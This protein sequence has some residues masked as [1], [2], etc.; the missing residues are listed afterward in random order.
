[1]KTF[2]EVEHKMG[3]IPTPGSQFRP[4][5]P[6][7]NPNIRKD[8]VT[9]KRKRA[10][11]KKKFRPATPKPTTACPPLPEAPQRPKCNAPLPSVPVRESTPWPG[12]GKV[13]GNLF[14]GRNWLLPQNHLATENKNENATGITSPRPPIKEELKT[15]EHSL[16]K[17]GWVPDCPFCKSQEKRK[18]EDKTQKQ[19]KAS[20]QAK[21]QKPQAR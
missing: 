1:M 4:P 13:S 12:A 8:T 2:L 7:T 11:P 10:T 9:E 6:D 16:E 21:L 19:L 3:P 18:E 14:E 15:N 20:P 5:L 17:C